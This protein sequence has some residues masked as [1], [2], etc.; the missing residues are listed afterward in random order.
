MAQHKKLFDTILSRRADNN[1]SFTGMCNLL[2]YLGFTERIRGGSHRIFTRNDIEE[3]I[4][5][6]PKEGK[7]KP[8]QVRQVRNLF[9][10]YKIE[11][12]EDNA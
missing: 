10:K 2:K 3:I 4:N 7:G 12:E 11:L 1:I 9:L 8:Y 5:L 6:Q